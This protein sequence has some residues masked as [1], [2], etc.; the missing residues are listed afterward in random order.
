MKDGGG[1]C[2]AGITSPCRT[3]KICIATTSNVEPPGPEISKFF[4]E[5]QDSVRCLLQFRDHI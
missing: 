5:I 4:Y 1:A 2:A 3:T